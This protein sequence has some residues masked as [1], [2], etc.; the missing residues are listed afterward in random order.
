MY[1]LA[2]GSNSIAPM[3]LQI[4]NLPLENI[5]RY[6]DCYLTE[7]SVV[8]YTRTGGGN[9]A[10]FDGS[11]AMLQNH[12]LYIKDEDDNMDCT[13]AHFYFS[14]PP[15]YE[16]QLTELFA[17]GATASPTDKWNLIF[18]QLKQ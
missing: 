9:R 3:L 17:S 16:K 10:A 15:E 2:C 14:F 13:Y 8:V 11:N 6:R 5:P 4:I 12:P 7:D 1:N 18:T